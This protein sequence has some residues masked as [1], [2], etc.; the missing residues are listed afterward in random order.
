M[1]NGKPVTSYY[2]FIYVSHC[3]DILDVLCE[4]RRTD[5]P[6]YAVVRGNVVQRG[7]E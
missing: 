1:K 6:E 2:L 3:A 5:S 4:Q 7:A